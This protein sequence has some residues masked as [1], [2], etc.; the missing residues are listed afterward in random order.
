MWFYGP[1]PSDNAVHPHVDVVSLGEVALHELLTLPLPLLCKA[2]DGRGRKPRLGAEELLQG[3]EEISAGETVEVQQRQDLGDLRRAAHVGRED[4]ALEP[5]PLTVVVHPTIIDSRSPNLHS[6][7][8]QQDLTFSGSPIADDQGMTVFITLVPGCLDVGLDLCFQCL[9]EH[10]PRSGASDLVE[11]E[12]ALLA[13]PADLMYAPHRCTPS[14]LRWRVGFPFDCSKGRYT[15]LKR[16]SPI[17]N[18]RSYLSILRSLSC[19]LAHPLET[20][21]R[22]SEA[23]LVALR[24]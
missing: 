22:P 8:S 17:H 12:H 23:N 3:R 10:S 21:W 14:R 16:K 4:H 20:P 15:T 6:P 5:A 7:G 2:G 9:G 24:G 11:I 1:S 13:I 18:F 19:A